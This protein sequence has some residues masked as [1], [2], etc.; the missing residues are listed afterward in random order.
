MKMSRYPFFVSV[1]KSGTK[2]SLDILFFNPYNYE[3][4]KLLFSLYIR[5]KT[6]ME[7]VGLKRNP[8]RAGEGG[9][10]VTVAGYEY[11]SGVSG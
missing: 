11:H 8:Q 10:L 1:R 6:L 5:R 7:T 4:Y 2:I 3:V 9:N